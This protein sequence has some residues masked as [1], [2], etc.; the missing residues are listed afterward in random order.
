M[1]ARLYAAGVP[2]LGCDVRMRRVDAPEAV[3]NLSATNGLQN[4][5]CL[6]ALLLEL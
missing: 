2:K 5:C 6:G 4:L 1:P 3:D